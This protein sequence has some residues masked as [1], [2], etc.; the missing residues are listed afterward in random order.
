MKTIMIL[1]A[2]QLQ[3]PIIARAK[4]KGLHVIVVSPDVSQPGVAY[5]DEVLTL[6]VRDQEKILAEA[7]KRG[8]DGITTDM[9]DL[10]VR[11]AAYVAEE[12][13]LPGIG[14]KMGELFT[15]KEKMREKALE[16]GVTVPKSWVVSS[17]QELL[18]IRKSIK[19]P[20]IIKPSDSQASHGV[21]RVDEDS[22]LSSGF[23]DAI[24]YSADG[25]VI[26]EEYIDGIEYAVDSVVRGGVCKMLSV[27]SY[28]PF[29]MPNV[30]ASSLSLFPPRDSEEVISLI[31]STNRDVIRGF[32]LL[33]GRTHAEYIVANGQCYLIEIAAR[34]GGA[35]FSSDNTRLISGFCSED[36]LL[37]YALG[38]DSGKSYESDETVGCCCT[39]YFF[40]QENCRVVSLE[41]L[42]EVINL[43]FIKR[44]N[45][46]YIKIG[47]ITPLIV[48]KNARK[49]LVIV[50]ENHQQLDERI[51]M[52]KR[53]LRI[54]VED[55]TGCRFPPIWR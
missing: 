34:G 27:C 22:I 49:F 10:P 31:E 50:A 12:M 54:E 13:K 19:Y 17:E 48:D 39:L 42:E 44:N 26:V 23:N 3:V 24:G 14:L 15:S 18:S 5:A 46:I 28:L 36:Y 8:I 33:D 25:R 55:L 1:G 9:T 7:I 6:D 29:E 40:L 41:G 20:A 52:I 38:A 21:T 11:T 30:F 4:E 47:D 53:L 16:I 43:D 51:A 35:Y 37:D 2:G 45:L 32:G